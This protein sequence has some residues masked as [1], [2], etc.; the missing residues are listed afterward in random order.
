MQTALAASN[1]TDEFDDLQEAREIEL[2]EFTP[3][4]R[5]TEADKSGDMKSLDRKLNRVLYLLVKKPRKEYEWQMPQGGVEPDESLIEVKRN[6][7][8]IVSLIMR[9]I[10]LIPYCETTQRLLHPY[11]CCIIFCETKV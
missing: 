1:E 7:Y 5:I 6:C 9:S 8:Y 3:A 10:V 4:S 2:H 11:I